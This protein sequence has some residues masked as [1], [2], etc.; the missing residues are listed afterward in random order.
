MGTVNTNRAPPIDT[1]NTSVSEDG[2]MKL[3][4]PFVANRPAEES[5][6]VSVFDYIVCTEFDK[7][8]GLNVT[9]QYP[10]DLPLISNQLDNLMGLI[11]PSNLQKFLNREHYTMVPMYID[12]A[13]SLLSY[14]KDTLTFVPCYLYSLSYFQNDN[15]YRN[16]TARAISIV[17]RLP[18]V[19]VFKPL[20]YFM[21]QNEFQESVSSLQIQTVWQNM[22]KMPIPEVIDAYKK[23]SYD[24]RF[25]LTRLDQGKPVLSSE[26]REF[27]PH[28]DGSLIKCTVNLGKI[29]FPIQIPETSLLC[30]R[31]AM[32][33]ADLQKDSN[34]SLIPL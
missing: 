4:S 8:K 21:L 31:L 10:L 3:L 32:Y 16:G 15:T 5:V 26:L 24:E 25:V 6:P 30:S 11:M 20:M 27:F 1:T 13:T 34:L 14:S 18:I 12:L 7:E 33:G 28:S 17:T 9:K 29:D 22:N 2:A 19:Q 23:L